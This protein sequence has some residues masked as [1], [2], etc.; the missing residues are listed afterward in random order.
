M[1]NTEELV[2]ELRIFRGLEK[3]PALDFDYGEA[4]TEKIEN[5]NRNCQEG[6]YLN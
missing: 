4:K 5:S 6:V 3:D 1:K 2:K